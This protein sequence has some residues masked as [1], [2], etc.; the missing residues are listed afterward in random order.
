MDTQSTSAQ[1]KLLIMK[2]KEF[3]NVFAA[4]SSPLFLDNQ[5]FTAHTTR[6]NYPNENLLSSRLLY[7]NVHK[8]ITLYIVLYGC[9]TWSLTLR[10]E[11][12][13]KV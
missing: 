13:P 12:R 11:N 8:S 4:N 5:Y 1:L 2:E 9:E 3:E 10:D 6:I 7:K